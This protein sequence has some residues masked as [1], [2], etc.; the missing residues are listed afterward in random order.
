MRAPLSYHC[1]EGKETYGPAVLLNNSSS[2]PPSSSASTD[3]LAL[4]LGVNSERL[5][6]EHALVVA[7]LESIVGQS[8][9]ELLSLS[10]N[11]CGCGTFLAKEEEEGV[12]LILF[13]KL[14]TYR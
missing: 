4:I 8:R 11:V 12:M 5:F 1:D 7:V 6:V 3:G 14:S 9:Q 13:S 2:S 10:K